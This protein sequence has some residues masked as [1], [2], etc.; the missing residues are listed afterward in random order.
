LTVFLYGARY[1]KS[2]VFLQLMAL[3]YYFNVA[4]GFNGLTLKVLGKIRYVVIINI[5]SVVISL[6]A[7]LLLVPKYGALGASIAT[8]GGM[9]IYNI[10]KQAGLRWLRG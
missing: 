8:A 1:E 6:I 7:C 10:L 4:L 5:L 9:I 2:Y 3:G